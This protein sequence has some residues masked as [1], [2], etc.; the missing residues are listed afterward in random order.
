MS[1]EF[2]ADAGT[3]K[4]D[5][6]HHHTMAVEWDERKALRIRLGVRAFGC[7]ELFGLKLTNGMKVLV[8]RKVSRMGGYIDRAEHLIDCSLPGAILGAPAPTQGFP[9]PDSSKD[10]GW[11]DVEFSSSTADGE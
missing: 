7:L 10:Q 4:A 8:P 2:T 6:Q 11:V 5:F 1:M 9:P 3:P